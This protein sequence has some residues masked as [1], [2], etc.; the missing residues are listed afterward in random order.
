MQR[1]RAI[2]GKCTPLQARLAERGGNSILEFASCRAAR[3][4]LEAQPV[5]LTQDAEFPVTLAWHEFQLAT[6]ATRA[7][8]ATSENARP[9]QRQLATIQGVVIQY[10]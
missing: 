5:V 3:R 4:S 6:G 1:F 7:R 9:S 10:V 2:A 8:R